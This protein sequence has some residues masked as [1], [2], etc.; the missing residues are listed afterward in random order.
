MI[1]KHE[2]DFWRKYVKNFRQFAG[3][4]KS[5]KPIDPLYELALFDVQNYLIGLRTVGGKFY[6]ELPEVTQTAIRRAYGDLLKKQT[7]ERPFFA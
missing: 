7:Q 5:A 2:M 4:S 3:L 1:P 6:W